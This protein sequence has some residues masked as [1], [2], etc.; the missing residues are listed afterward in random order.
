M[1]KVQK[2]FDASRSAL[3][4]VVGGVARNLKTLLG[5]FV[6]MGGMGTQNLQ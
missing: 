1:F 2:H 3:E 6:E 5:E 4:G